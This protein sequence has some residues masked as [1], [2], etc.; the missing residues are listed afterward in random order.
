MSK[1]IG[2]DLG[3]GNSCV[4]VIE[5]GTPT[6]I[7]NDTGDR[8]TPSFVAY[9]DGNITVGKAAKNGAIT[10]AKNTIY[11][12][13]RFMGNKYSEMKDWVNI[14]PY[15]VT[16][17][18]NGDARVNV[19]GKDLSPEEISAKILMKMKK[20]AEDYLGTEV[21]D[22]VITVPAYF[23]DAQRQATK[24]A[25]KIAGLNVLRLVAEP[26][27]AAIAFGFDKKELNKKLA[28]VDAG[29]GTFD[30]SILDVSDG[31]FEVLATSGDAKLGGTDFDNALVDYICDEFKKTN[32]VDLRTDSMA[33]QR[34]KE[35]AE[36]AKIALSSS[37]T[38]SV[39]LPFITADSTG[40][41]HLQ[42]EISRSKF[43]A[44]IHDLIERHRAPM[45]QA[46]KD[47]GLSTSDIDDVLLVGG[48]TRVP[49]IQNLV[50]EVFGKE[51]NKSVNPD[52]AVA[53]GA[54]IQGGILNNDVKQDIVLLDVTPLSLGIETAG[55][56]FTKLIDKNTTIPT[57]KSQIFSTYADGQTAVTIHVLQGERPMAKD[58]RTLGN[59]N[60][61]GIPA[62]PRG[63]PQISVEFSLN[64]DGLLSV[65]AKDMGTGKE[66]KITIT[67]GSGLSD[68][69]IQR[70]VKEAEEHAEE[71]KKLREYADTK[72][73]A[74]S[75][76]GS[77]E[78]TLKELGDKVTSDEKTKIED[79]IK[80]LKESLDK[81]DDI[82][83]IKSKLE[84]LKQSSYSIAQKLYETSNA[85]PNQEAQTNSNASG[86][87]D[88]VEY[89]VKDA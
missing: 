39:N 86:K 21:K 51:G 17:G 80:N 65:T 13:K 23:N 63:V 18:S 89:E 73:E 53:I 22:A 56:V 30:V 16:E 66:Q 60:L 12:I 82:N 70:M 38:T 33:L 41:K 25:G 72:N 10:N 14:V 55:G 77:T 71:D 62:A 47:A 69:E 64:S 19:D 7:V 68:E 78:K 36:N 20:T 31:V 50:K 45:L 2:I 34:I 44:I 6:V 8:T 43:E 5:N 32:G 29:S 40:P 61:D 27:A 35:A 83:T 54:S 88:D 4:S 48:T 15:K 74:E 59:F 9:K 75:F 67:N 11:A 87:A 24:N 37:T 58:N 26:T 42:M 81:N 28:V 3:T 79:N 57:K 52:E 49:A 85:Q 84:E 46:L 76:I 1:V